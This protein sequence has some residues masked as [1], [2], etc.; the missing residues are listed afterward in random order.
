MRGT[1]LGITTW[2]PPYTNDLGPTCRHYAHPA[3]EIMRGP[4]LEFTVAHLL[5]ISM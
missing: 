5:E 3:L 2:G 4:F 1:P